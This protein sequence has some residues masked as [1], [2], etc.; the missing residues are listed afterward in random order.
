MLTQW[1]GWNVLTDPIFSERCSPV[2]WAGPKRLRPSPVQAEDLPPVDVCVIS[3]NHYDHLD[4]QTVV[5]LNK[6]HQKMIWMVPLGM[7]DWMTDIGVH[8]VVELDWSEKVTI[9]DLSGKNRPPLTLHCK[10]LLIISSNFPG[11]PCQHWCSR[12]RFDKNMCLWS[13]WAATT[14]TAGFF[15]GGDTGYC[16]IFA[17]IGRTIPNITLSAIPI[18]AYGSPKERWFHQYN[19]MNPS[20]AVQTHIDL[21]SKW[22]LGVHWGTFALTGE[23]IME[24]PLLLGKALQV[25]IYISLS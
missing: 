6:I 17:K 23:P 14:S 5:S 8:N 18:G 9:S 3:H 4:A 21:N 20:E 12:T 10:L 22:S 13:S 15:F 25:C 11:L 7:R 19:H 24:P 2:Q 1:D 16:P